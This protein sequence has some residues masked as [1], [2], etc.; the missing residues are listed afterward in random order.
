MISLLLLM[1]KPISNYLQIISRQ[2]QLICGSQEPASSLDTPPSSFR[3]QVP[4]LWCGEQRRWER[5]ES[6]PRRVPKDLLT[7]RCPRT[8]GT[9]H[10]DKNSAGRRTLSPHPKS[11]SEVS[12]H[13][14]K[15]KVSGNLSTC[16]LPPFPPPSPSLLRL[17][18]GSGKGQQG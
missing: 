3:W 13:E 7:P 11:Q 10:S 15:W 6:S 1:F 5:K 9:Q 14:T 17:P 4:G 12:L 18:A 8:A 16:S 2:V